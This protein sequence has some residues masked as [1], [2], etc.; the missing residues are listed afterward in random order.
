MYI[1]VMITS[2]YLIVGNT[3]PKMFKIGSRAIEQEKHQNKL[4]FCATKCNYNGKKNH[5]QSK[6]ANVNIKK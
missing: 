4:R 5:T 1:Y 3:T 2:I 6:Q